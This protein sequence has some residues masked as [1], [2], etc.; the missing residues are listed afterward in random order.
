MSIRKVELED[1]PLPHPQ[2]RRRSK[3]ASFST[4]TTYT[5]GTDRFFRC[6]E[7][8]QVGKSLIF[9]ATF[10]KTTSPFSRSS[11]SSTEDDR[12]ELPP[13]MLPAD[14]GAELE[15]P[16]KEASLLHAGPEFGIV[17]EEKPEKVMDVGAED[18][19]L[20]EVGSGL[21]SRTPVSTFT[22]TPVLTA[23]PRTYHFNQR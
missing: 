16:P 9:P 23:A 15:F 3:R 10:P 21:C 7:D 14:V 12:N 8:L 19:S 17:L 1:A 2:H 4:S 13:I 22:K 20:V 11:F 5:R 18:E 6:I